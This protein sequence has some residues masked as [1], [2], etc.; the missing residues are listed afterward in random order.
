MKFRLTTL[1]H[2][3]V[4]P[5]QTFRKYDPEL[6]DDSSVLSDLCSLLAD[7]A[8]ARFEVECCGL[9]WPVDVRTDLAIILPQIPEVLSELAEERRASLQFFEQGIERKVV[10]AVRDGDVEVSCCDLWDKLLAEAHVERIRRTSL[11]AELSELALDFIR[12]VGTRYPQVAVIPLYKHWRA[13]VF[14]QTDRV[15]RK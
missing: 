13:D 3:E 7:D 6:D 14:E 8:V 9:K 1:D 10:F 5:N 12:L 2:K 4:F 11:Y 15:M